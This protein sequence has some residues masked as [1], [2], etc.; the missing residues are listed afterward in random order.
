[1]LTTPLTL[2]IVLATFLLSAL[3]ILFLVRKYF[4]F[5]VFDNTSN[6][7]IFS[8]AIGLI[9]GLTLAFISVSVWQSY[10]NINSIVIEEASTLL[11]IRRNLDAFQPEVREKGNELLTSYVKNVITK[12][13]P[14]MAKGQLDTKTYTDIHLFHLLMLRHNPINNAE[15]IAQQEEIRLMSQYNKMR[16][17]RITSAKSALDNPMIL[18]L[19]LSA[20]VFI[21]YQCFYSMP[22]IRDHLFMISFLTISIGLLFFLILSYN[23]PFWGPNAIPPDEFQRLLEIWKINLD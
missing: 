8:D 19:V 2:L 23:T 16:A 22:K 21:L 13:W 1:M 9:F 15:F 10:N 5:F 11:S 7:E 6:S 4:S 18:T 17:Q 20:A 14:M 3:A 12:E